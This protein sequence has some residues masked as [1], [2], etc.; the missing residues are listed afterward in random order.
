MFSKCHSQMMVTT[1]SLF[2][3]V[4]IITYTKK[5]TYKLKV[6]KT[7]L[8]M[9]IY[10]I[11]KGLISIL[12]EVNEKVKGGLVSSCK[13]VNLWYWIPWT[14]FLLL[15]SKILS[16]TA[17]PH[18]LKEVFN[19]TFAVTSLPLLTIRKGRVYL[20]WMWSHLFKI[21]NWI[22]NTRLENVTSLSDQH[23]DIAMPKISQPKTASHHLMTTKISYFHLNIYI[24]IYI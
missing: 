2:N 6:I 5:S 13:I 22:Y 11:R 18:P 15:H 19:L 8:L 17:Q 4:Y 1:E 3:I 24:Y 7:Y 12:N 14:K 20:L 16:F 23:S 10:L 9:D 21:Y